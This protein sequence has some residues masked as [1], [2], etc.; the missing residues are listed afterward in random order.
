MPKFLEIFVL[1]CTYSTELALHLCENQLS[2]CTTQFLF[3]RR[4]W[5]QTQGLFGGWSSMAGAEGRAEN[6][7]RGQQSKE[8]GKGQGS[9]APNLGKP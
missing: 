3:L 7:P 8:K 4:A 5:D 2:I 9:H 6:S 1:K